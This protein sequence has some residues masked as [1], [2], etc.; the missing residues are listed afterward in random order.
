[1]IADSHGINRRTL[2]LGGCAALA[3]PF[4]LTSPAFAAEGGA[5]LPIPPILDADGA[6]P[7]T[8]TA[9]AGS[10]SFVP[11]TKTPT[12]GYELD[13]LGPTLRVRRGRSARIDVV[14]R[15]G[16]EISAH[17]HG[18]FVPGK[19][20][21]GP[22]GAFAPGKTSSAR[23]DVHQPA[24]TL[25]YHSHVHGKTG[26]QVY[27]G[28]AGLLLVEDPAA[29]D[30]LPADYG[31][32]DLPL[33]VQ[34][35]SFDSSGRLV[36]N[37][38]GMTL[39]SG[40]LGNTICVNG[41]V[42]PVADVPRGL[43]R[44]RILNG[45]NA[46]FYDFGFDD[47]RQFHQ[48]ASDSGLLP[49]PVARTHLALAPAERAEIVVDFS[50]DNA[51]VRLVSADFARSGMMGGGMMGGGSGA[52]ATYDIATFVPGGA[53]GTGPTALPVSLPA[54]PFDLGAPVR[55]RDIRLDMHAGTMMG[56][57][58]RRLT[59]SNGGVMGINGRSYDMGRID[60]ELK[61]GETE[62]WRVAA[63]MMT[64]PFHVHGCSFQVVSRGGQAVD[65]ATEGHKDVVVVDARG[66]EILV[67]VDQK[68][69][70]ATPFMMH[71]HILEHEDA[72]MMAQFT[73]A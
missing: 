61:L 40:F 52:P 54:P 36:Y 19:M 29:P 69:D 21:G 63:P 13:Y 5:A 11:G 6:Q 3:A 2:L 53:A 35:R 72:G 24:A 22:Q 7:V 8:L 68:A 14:N 39:M 28:L 18:A 38:S 60:A 51:P 66:V 42:R 23:F 16:D 32:N 34:D 1:M 30:G 33:V 37:T 47:G 70:R 25:W 65:P 43:V 71:C 10:H 26:T 67:R 50:G 64:H 17:W 9:R 55:T 12:L 31:V 49:A 48:V 58:L 27:H 44:L 62:L 57:M 56:S 73:V 46:R 20:D 41:A 59:G 45:S 15:T 4:V